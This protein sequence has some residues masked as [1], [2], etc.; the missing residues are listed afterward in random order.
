MSGPYL[1][2]IFAVEHLIHAQVALKWIVEKGLPIATKADKTEYLKEDI[3]MF[4]W[5]L[6]K[7]DNTALSA[8]TTPA[9]VPSWACTA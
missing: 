1:H 8:M 6:T 2:F 4:S 7:A 5:N 3:D 9:G